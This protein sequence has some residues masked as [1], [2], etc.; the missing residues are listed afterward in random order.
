MEI[1]TLVAR[2]TTANQE[3]DRYAAELT[4]ARAKIHELEEDVKMTISNLLVNQRTGENMADQVAA[5]LASGGPPAAGPVSP[6][7]PAARSVTLSEENI[8]AFNRMVDRVS[9]MEDRLTRTEHA[10]T[11]L[12]SKPKLR[13]LLKEFWSSQS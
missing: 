12:A 7:A 1:Q 9:M 10:L 11:A 5:M 2:V 4:K 6:G 3:R 13:K 8:A